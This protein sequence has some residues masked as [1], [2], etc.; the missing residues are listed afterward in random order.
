ML[1]LMRKHLTLLSLPFLLAPAIALAQDEPEPEAEAGEEEVVGA[2]EEALEEEDFSFESEGDAPA[3]GS[4]NPGDPNATF[5]AGLKD[6][7]KKSATKKQTGYP[8]RIINRP[9]NLPGGMSQAQL[10]V[11]VNFDPLVA[12]GV[13][14]GDYGITSQ[15]QI[16]LEYGLGT[17]TSDGFATGKALALEGRYLIA[18]WVA[19]QVRLPVY[20]DP[21]AAGLT[22][23][24]PMQFT[25][26]DKMRFVFGQDLVSFKLAKFVP[27]VANAA[28]NDGLI[29]K[30]KIGEL[31][32]DG[33][34]NIS[35]TVVYQM[36]DTM[37]ID[38]QFG[39]RAVDFSTDDAPVYLY[40]GIRYSPSNK[41]DFGARIGFGRLDDALETLGV[42]LFAAI[43]I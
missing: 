1:R 43:R 8:Q 33:E 12:S 24:A 19:A 26:F 15:Y 34:I 3:G 32:P 42:D 16:G 37:T 41:L 22:L 30:D 9:L 39:M 10:R 35:M 6:K 31:V 4:E 11:P 17:Y 23:G 7:P 25:F 2:E 27:N 13:I 28:E 40:S 20:L 36:D 29:A 38:T 18:D 21:F 5:N 14:R